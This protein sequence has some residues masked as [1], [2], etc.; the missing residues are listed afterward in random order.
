MSEFTIGDRVRFV[1]D[2]ISLLYGSSGVV[3]A[4]TPLG[5]KVQ[6]DGDTHTNAKYGWGLCGH[7]LEHASPTPPPNTVP[8]RIAVAVWPDG[9]WRMEYLDPEIAGTRLSWITA[10][11]PLPEQPAEV[12]G[13]VE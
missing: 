9:T 5:Y 1:G 6:I 10:H 2:K 7:E 13:K 4:I 11:V 3:V 8:V 12:E